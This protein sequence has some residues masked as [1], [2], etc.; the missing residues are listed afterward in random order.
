MVAFA[1]HAWTILQLTYDVRSCCCTLCSPL[2]PV[3]SIMLSTISRLTCLSLCQVLVRKTVSQHVKRVH[4]IPT[5][6]V[7]DARQARQ[8]DGLPLFSRPAPFCRSIDRG[9][10]NHDPGLARLRRPWSQGMSLA[11][12][13]LSHRLFT[14]YG[15]K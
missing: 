1:G 5:A 8:G 3:Y 14:F 7:Q 12:R 15:E 2:A 10:S 4:K 9:S 6:R 11:C 13:H